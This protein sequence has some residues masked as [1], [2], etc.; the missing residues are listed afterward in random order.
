M[1]QEK[2]IPLARTVR[3][4]RI[5][6][7]TI[8]VLSFLLAVVASGWFWQHFGA[9]AR[10]VG[11]VDSPRVDVVSP[12]AGLVI[13]L[14]HQARG[15]WMVYDHVQAG[16]VIARIEDQ[17]L[18]ISK[19]L[20]RQ[21]VT[22]LLDQL[23]ERQTETAADDGGDPA[24]SEAVRLAWQYEQSQ[25]LSLDE[26]L[27]AGAQVTVA[28]NYDLVSAPAELPEAVPAASREALARLRET[29]RGLE[30]RR[31]ELYLS[32]QSLEIQSPI[33]GTL[34]AVHCW[35]GQMVPPGGVI[36]TVAADYGRNIVGY[37]PEESSLVARPGMR[38]TLRTR[39]AGS[40]RL[41]SEI[42]QVALQIERIPSHQRTVSTTPQW[43]TPVRIKMP[44]D[45]V[46]QP[47]ALVD[48]VFDGSGGQ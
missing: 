32:T 37:I 25:L 21:E 16:D 29:R 15:Q 47:G 39:V 5:R 27:A 46:L 18:E 24:A 43:G 31:K 10:G 26:Q 17:Q 2:R 3:W 45:A 4:R 34:V 44:S 38:V 12:T 22:Q 28:E 7:Q 48:V 23:K 20:L 36:A 30:L 9:A 8:P 40:R 19:N 1:M 11:E 33:S 35:P 6:S 42:E 41:T 13:S 14:P